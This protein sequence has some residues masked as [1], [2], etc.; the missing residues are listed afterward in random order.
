MKRSDIKEIKEIL[1]TPKNVVLVPHKNPD[2]TAIGTTFVILYAPHKGTTT[3]RKIARKSNEYIDELEE[4]Y[5]DFLE[6]ITDK[7]EDLKDK[8]SDLAEKAKHEAEKMAK[9]AQDEAEKMTEK[10]KQEAEKIAK[11]T[12]HK[13]GVEA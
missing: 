9:K 13:E 5:D 1:S 4:K 8:A 3:R 10:A 11:K 6:D 12:K 2:G 7:F